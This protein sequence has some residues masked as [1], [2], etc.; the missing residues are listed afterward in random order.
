MSSDL[1][2][3]LGRALAGVQNAEVYARQLEAQME[4]AE[5]FIVN[6]EHYCRSIEGLPSRVEWDVIC[7]TLAAALRWDYDA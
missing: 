6:L 7:D 1:E 3:E 2:V 5:R 4:K